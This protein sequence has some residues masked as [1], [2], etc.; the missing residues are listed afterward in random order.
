MTQKWNLQDIRPAEPRRK[1]SAPK[2]N[3]AQDTPD[4][5]DN[6]NRTIQIQNGNKRKS[7]SVLILAATFTTVILGTLG[8]SYLLQGVE[9]EVE[10]RTQQ[11]NLNAT[12][13]AFNDM[14]P[15]ELSYELL[16]ISDQAE[17]QVSASGEVEEEIFASGRI[18]IFNENTNP[19]QLVTNTRFSSPDGMIYRIS[20][21]VT[22]P[23]AS[24][25]EGQIIPGTLQVTITADNVGDEYN[26]DNT[27]RFTIP[28]FAESNLDQLYE[29]VY[30]ENS[31]PITGGFSGLRLQISEEDRQIARQELQMELRERLR[32]RIDSERPA[33]FI[34]YPNAVTFT[35]EALP[36]VEYNDGMA[37]MIE[38]AVLR[39]PLFKQADLANYLAAATIPGYQG[40]PVRLD[41]ASELNFTYNNTALNIDLSLNESI[42]FTLTGRPF[43]IWNFDH[44]EL[45]SKMLNEHKDALPRILGEFPAIMRGSVRMQ[46]F[47]QRNFPSNPEQIEIIEVIN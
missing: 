32:E 5:T 21:G 17:K 13:I 8:I 33:D 40:E 19:Q 16:E 26:I 24:Q 31:S 6:V 36:A 41:N 47:W 22:I 14:R 45:R 46:P 4:S 35:F 44:D 43:L 12:I 15:G 18:T 11:P 9:L 30:A 20:E 29:T 25:S 2:K 37:T 34:Y 28:G 42:E 27:V 23:P 38:Q 3:V 10:P 39:V 1:Q 7:K